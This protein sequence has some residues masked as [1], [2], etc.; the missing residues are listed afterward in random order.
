MI[1]Q[2]SNFIVPMKAWSN[3]GVGQQAQGGE[4]SNRM[5]EGSVFKSVLQDTIQN[6]YDTQRDLEQKEY[7]LATGQIEDAHTLPIAQAK[8]ELNLEVMIS[9]RNKAMEAYNELVK[10]NV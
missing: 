10:L 1:E 2:M 5:Q 4:E 6:V 3:I 7:L 9:L 8:A